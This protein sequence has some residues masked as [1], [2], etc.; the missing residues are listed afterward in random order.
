LSFFRKGELM[1]M[2]YYSYCLLVFCLPCYLQF[3]L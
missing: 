2:P 3:R 1:C